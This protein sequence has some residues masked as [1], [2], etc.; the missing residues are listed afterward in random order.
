M[1][2]RDASGDAS[3]KLL[4]RYTSRDDCRTPFL[5]DTSRDG[6]DVSRDDHRLPFF[7]DTSR[8]TSKNLLCRDHWYRAQAITSD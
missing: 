8:D 4:C 6:R 3:T 2:H 7:R 1:F 5:R